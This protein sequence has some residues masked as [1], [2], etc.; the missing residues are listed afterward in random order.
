MPP[1][2]SSNK[3]RHLAHLASN[4]ERKKKYDIA[5]QLWEKV[6]QHALSN[7]NIEWA[8]RRKNFCLKQISSYKKNQYI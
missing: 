4:A 6:L 1:K 3:T 8:F 2:K 7:E 5:A